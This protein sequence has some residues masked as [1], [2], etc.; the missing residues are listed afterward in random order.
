M[1]RIRFVLLLTLGAVAAL[2]LP[3]G[4]AAPACTLST[5]Q[6][7]LYGASCEV[8]VAANANNVVIV[9]GHTYVY[10]GSTK[11][12]GVSGGVCYFNGQSLLCVNPGTAVGTGGT[13]AS[14]WL[15][16]GYRYGPAA[17]IFSYRCVEVPA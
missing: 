3:S 14:A 15:C 4:A 12:A 16:T 7:N 8:P 5:G 10:N 11:L 9:G 2:A 1:R 13:P 17:A 6:S